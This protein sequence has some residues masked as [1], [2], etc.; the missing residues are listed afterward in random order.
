MNIDWISVTSIVMAAVAVV[1]LIIQYFKEE[2]PWEKL[3]TELKMKVAKIEQEDKHVS[4]S[5]ELLRK[6]MDE[7]DDRTQKN[8]ERVDAKLEKLTDLMIQLLRNK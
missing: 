8:M 4:N 1:G 7:N 6:V 2:R 5:I 3:I